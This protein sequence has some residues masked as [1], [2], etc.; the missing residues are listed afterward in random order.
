MD[1]SQ[2]ENIWF[3]RIILKVIDNLKF[4]HKFHKDFDVHHCLYLKNMLTHHK[5]VNKKPS[6]HR[7][8]D[9]PVE[10]RHEAREDI[11]GQ[12]V[13]VLSKRYVVSCEQ[14]VNIFS[15][16]NYTTPSLKSAKK[17]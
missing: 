14:A 13:N 6:Y 12:N 17:L 1:R 11:R 15:F 16:Q 3:S 4:K 10:T 7:S 2:E 8:P 9:V 5:S